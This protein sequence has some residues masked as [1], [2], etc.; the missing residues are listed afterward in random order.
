MARFEPKG[1]TIVDKFHAF[2]CAKLLGMPYPELLVKPMREDLTRFGVQETRTPEEVDDV[3]RNTKG[4]LMVVVNSVCGC[5]A[6]SGEILCRAGG[7]GLLL[8]GA[9][10]VL[11]GSV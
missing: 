3:V 2:Q 7:G 1:G 11:V 10:A 4:T 6:D 9:D 5:A 8:V